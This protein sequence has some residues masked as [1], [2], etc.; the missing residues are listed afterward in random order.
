MRSG[1]SHD[2]VRRSYDEVAEE[3]TA[4]LKD[5]LTCKPLDRALLCALIEQTEADSPIAD[6]GC[7]GHVAAWVASHGAKAV[8]IDLSPRTTAVG[9]RIYP[10]VEFR[11]GDFLSL[12]AEDSESSASSPSTPSFIWKLLIC[13]Q[14]S[15]RSEGCCDPLV[16]S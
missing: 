3:Y 11:E 4:H 6:V 16:S 8:G 9:R 5:E 13:I 7:P 15:R 14:L 1:E 10:E 12:P 2:S